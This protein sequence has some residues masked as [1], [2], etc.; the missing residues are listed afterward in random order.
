MRR[1]FD[2]TG[3]VGVSL[4]AATLE[5]LFREAALAL[6]ETLTELDSVQPD[7]DE[8]V[9]LEAASLN[10]LVVIWLDELLY[11]FE[12]RSLLVHDVDVKVAEADGGWR[13]DGALHGERFDESRHA[14]KVLIKGVTYHQLNV[15]HEGQTW[16]TDVIFDI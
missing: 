13:L 9:G 3:D 12:V 10:D 14:I 16:C 5:D 15:R 7:E 11:R 8:L 6:T 2:H 1:F 4:A